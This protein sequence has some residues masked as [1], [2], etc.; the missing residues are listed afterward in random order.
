MASVSNITNK[1][2]KN[3]GKTEQTLI[4]TSPSQKGACVGLS[5]ANV[6]NNIVKASVYLTD[7]T[8]V[9]GHYIKDLEIAPQSSARIINGGEKLLLAPSNTVSI[10]CDTT[11]GLDV[12]FSLVVITYS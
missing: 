6:T 9:K 3:L 12:I 10:V 8:S 4:S 7:A 1:V 5:L 2:I 11:D